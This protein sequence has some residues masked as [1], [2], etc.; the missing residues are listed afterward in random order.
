MALY[1]L[2]WGILANKGIYYTAGVI[3]L[4]LAGCNVMFSY[5]PGPIALLVLAVG[6]FGLLWAAVHGWKLRQLLKQL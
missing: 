3:L 6:M 5:I 1:L 4:L 2:L